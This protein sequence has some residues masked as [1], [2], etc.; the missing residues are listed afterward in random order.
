MVLDARENMCGIDKW[1]YFFHFFKN[2]NDGL[3]NCEDNNIWPAASVFTWDSDYITSVFTNTNI[4][5][6]YPI[7][8]RQR[9]SEESQK[10][11]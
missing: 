6:E 5:M 1:F 9:K 7:K 10:K 11:S 8:Q 2:G 4:I 3:R